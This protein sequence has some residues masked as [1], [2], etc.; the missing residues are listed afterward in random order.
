MIRAV[1]SRPLTSVKSELEL[2]DGITEARD[3]VEPFT[4]YCAATTLNLL[5][6]LL[7]DDRS[8][9]ARCFD[10]RGQVDAEYSFNELHLRLAI[11]RS[12]FTAFFVS[13]ETTVGAFDSLR[14]QT[15]HEV[16]AK[17]APVRSFEVL[18]LKKKSRLGWC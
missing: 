12:S 6:T 3:T 18:S 1:R 7:N 11:G 17:V 13:L 14:Y 4:L 16:H 9:R 15:P 5:D 2:V 8:D 10:Q